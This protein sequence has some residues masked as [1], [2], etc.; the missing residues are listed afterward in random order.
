MLSVLDVSGR[1]FKRRRVLVEESMK[2]VQK[3]VAPAEI[4]HLLQLLLLG[5]VIATKYSRDEL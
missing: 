3:R 2:Y 5:H 1:T 4:H